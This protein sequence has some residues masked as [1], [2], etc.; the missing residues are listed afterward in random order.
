[1]VTTARYIPERGDVVWLSHDPQRGHEQAG[2]RPA[3]VLSPRAYN[4]R[5]HNLAVFVPITSQPKG[6]KFEVPVPPSS[7]ATGVILTDHIK[8]LDWVA[9]RAS[10]IGRVP[11]ST[12]Q[13]VTKI[14]ATFL[15]LP[16]P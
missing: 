7:G 12:I 9:R 6:F 14:I 5:S 4:E 13:N 10:Y 3:L 16:A 15:A 2:R 8:S 1:L 11:S